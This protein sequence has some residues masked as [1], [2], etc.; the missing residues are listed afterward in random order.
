[1]GLNQTPSFKKRFYHVKTKSL[2]VASLQEL[3]Q[4]MDQVQ[5]QAFRKTYGK[6]WDLAMIEVSVEAITSITHYYD[7]PLRCFTFGD[8]QLVPIVEEFEGI[9]GCPLGGRKSYFFS[10]LYPSMAR[11]AKVVKILAQE[12]D[13][14]KQNINGVVGIPRK[15]LEEKEKALADQGEWTS[16]V[17]VLALLVF[18]IALFPNVDGLVDLVAIDAFLTYHHNKESLV[19]AILADA[20]DIF[21]RRCE[22]NNKRIVYC[23]PALYVWLVSHFSSW[24]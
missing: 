15:H 18:G 10:G 9:L 3:G 11:V 19:I 21:D 6:I 20:Y 5:R 23:T 8:F 7:Q 1:M 13:R 14:A 22:K 4:Q 16:F 2:K 24:K 17:D 12:L